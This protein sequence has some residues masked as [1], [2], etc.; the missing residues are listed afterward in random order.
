MIGPKSENPILVTGDVTIDWNLARSRRSRSGPSV[1]SADDTI[2]AYWQRGGAALLAGEVYRAV[3]GPILERE[4]AGHEFPVTAMAVTPDGKRIVSGGG[5]GM[6]RIWNL[7]GGNLEHVFEG[8]DYGR[9]VGIDGGYVRSLAVTQDG[10]RI[11]SGG[12]DCAVRIRNLATGK[13]ECVLDGHAGDVNAVA[14]APDGDRIVSAG[15]D[16]TVRVW[17]LPTGSQERELTSDQ[18]ECILLGHT[19]GVHT[20]TVTPDG[21]RVISGAAQEED[22]LR[23]WSLATGRL[24]RK[25]K[26]HE[27]QTYAVAITSDGSRIISGGEDG[28]VRIWDFSKGYPLRTLGNHSGPVLAVAVTPDGRRIVSGDAEGVVLISDLASGRLEFRFKAHTSQAFSLAVT[29]DGR[30]IISGGGDG[31]IRIWSVSSQ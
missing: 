23:V 31:A 22:T 8:V 18:P 27:G 30:R 11:V 25:L 14:V 19:G 24:E 5:D 6:V 1:W 2:R 12:G 9:Y 28:T 4:L 16:Y 7:T 17:N 26:G 20:V 13:L 10:D 15:F 29:P 3:D 21:R